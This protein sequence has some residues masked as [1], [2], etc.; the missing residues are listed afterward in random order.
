MPYSSFS[1][2]ILAVFRLVFG[3]AALCASGAAALAA[4]ASA[5]IFGRIFHKNISSLVLPP[6]AA[7]GSLGFAA[8]RGF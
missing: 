8:E 5:A 3:R 4:A 1:V 2:G 6:N 7:F